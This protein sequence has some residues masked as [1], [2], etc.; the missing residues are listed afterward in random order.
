MRQGSNESALESYLE[1]FCA[2]LFTF[3]LMQS[4]KFTV[5]NLKCSN[6][7]HTGSEGG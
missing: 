5:T 6:I 3:N 2:H 7:L 4:F 1:P